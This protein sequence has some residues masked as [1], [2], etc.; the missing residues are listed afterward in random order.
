MKPGK[1]LFVTTSHDELG[2]TGIKTGVWLEEFATPYYI[3]KEAGSE[4]SVASPKGG[5]VPTDPKSLAIILATQNTKRFLKDAEA[6]HLLS[7]STELASIKADDFDA[8]FL[9]GGHG[10]MWDL[11]DNK[12]L[13]QLLEDFDRAGKPIGAVCHGV[14]GLLTMI[15]ENGGHGVKGK[16]LTSFSNSEEESTNLTNVVP[17]LLETKLVSLGASYSK[18]ANY[19]SHVVVDG[20]FITGQ[21]PASSGEVAKRII[22]LLKG[23]KLQS[24]V[25]AATDV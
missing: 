18:E 11:A 21:N 15:N 17:F 7:H 20:H 3:F 5:Q 25:H 14:A 6:L 19:I 16:H 23:N 13:K 12:D 10:P 4:V 2:N 24:S 22:G 1:I 8:I 9:P